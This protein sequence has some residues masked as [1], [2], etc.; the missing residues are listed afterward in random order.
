MPCK[1]GKPGERGQERKL[2]GKGEDGEAKDGGTGFQNLSTLSSHLLPHPV[3][4]V[5]V[6][7]SNFQN[8]HLPDK[9]PK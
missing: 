9:I 3:P 4:W 5:R 8:L 2:R 6:V 7:G 1:E